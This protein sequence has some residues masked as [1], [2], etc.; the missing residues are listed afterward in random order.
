MCFLA[1]LALV[2]LQDAKQRLKLFNRCANSITA[3]CFNPAGS[4]YAYAIGYDWSVQRSSECM[5]VLSVWCASRSLIR[6][7][8][9]VLTCVRC[10]SV[11]LCLGRREWNIISVKR[12][13]AASCCT[14][15]QMQR[16]RRRRSKRASKEA[17]R[18]RGIEHEFCLPRRAAAILPLSLSLLSSLYH[19]SHTCPF[20]RI[21]IFCTRS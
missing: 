21:Q 6:V 7:A 19:L 11:V 12:I 2:C 14:Q 17:R 4:I 16:S 8:S 5:F 20:F 10:S 1:V 13:P 18:T 15:S 9:L 3:S